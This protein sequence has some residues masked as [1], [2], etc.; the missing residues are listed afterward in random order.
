MTEAGCAD[1][2]LVSVESVEAR[3]DDVKSDDR[4]FSLIE[5]SN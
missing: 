5:V 1:N 2:V 4:D 3:H